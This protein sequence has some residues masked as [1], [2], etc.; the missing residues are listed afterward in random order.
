[1]RE[2]PDISTPWIGATRD[3]E[4]NGVFT[5]ITTGCAVTEELWG[6]GEPNDINSAE[7]CVFFSGNPKKFHDINCFRTD[8]ARDYVCQVFQ[9]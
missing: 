1:M 4:N 6:E 7:D 2:I 3:V 5:F 8:L 9:Q